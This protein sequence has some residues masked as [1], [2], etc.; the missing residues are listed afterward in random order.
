VDRLRA[1]LDE[2]TPHYPMKARDDAYLA[3]V[4]APKAEASSAP[5]GPAPVREATRE[6]RK[7]RPAMR[8]PE[9]TGAA[10]L[11]VLLDDPVRVDQHVETLAS[12][13]CGRF[14]VLRERMVN[15]AREGEAVLLGGVAESMLQ[16]LRASGAAPVRYSADGWERA[17][18]AHTT[19]HTPR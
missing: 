1:I 14:D 9:A 10:L 16:E 8:E 7:A 6:A 4:E 3:G 19:R 17:A 2:P 18:R 15:F 13:P 11:A 12:L 5:Q